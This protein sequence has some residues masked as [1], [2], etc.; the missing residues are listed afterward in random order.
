MCLPS[1]FIPTTNRDRTKM[2]QQGTK[3][4]NLAFCLSL[5]LIVSISLIPNILSA[6][7]EKVFGLND[8]SVLLPLEDIRVNSNLLKPQDL[9][10]GGS[11]LPVD[12]FERLP[13][14]RMNMTAQDRILMYESLRVLA[15]RIDPCFPATA[16]PMAKCLRQIRLVWQPVM[17]QQGKVTTVDAAVHTFHNLQDHEFL[18]LLKDWP[19]SSNPS[20]N[21]QVH[22]QFSLGLD[23][24]KW[25]MTKQILLNNIGRQNLWKV[26][27]M[28]LRGQD[29]IWLFGGFDVG[30]QGLVA[31]SIPRLKGQK[32]QFFVN[33]PK[34]KEDF[35][36]GMISPLP[37]VNEDTLNLLTSDSK[38]IDLTKDE[39]QIIQEIWASQR[40]DNPNFHSPQT[41]DCV[42]CHVSQAARSFAEVKFEGL[43]QKWQEQDFNYINSDFRL[44]NTS[45]LKSHTMNIRAF[46]YFE[47]QPAISQR[48]INETAQVASAISVWLN[49]NT[50]NS[51][52]TKLSP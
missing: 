15:I 13:A 52:R 6:S 27:F 7:A 9:G 17:I 12:F 29:H 30:N 5:G 8:V 36:N 20:V 50:A 38:K 28:A 33:G 10:V 49:Q 11:L 26:T 44:E 39:D 18:K 43:K 1:R 32:S 4:M 21:L 24:S 37:E 45:P 35:V 16:D 42:S 3:A 2:N 51:G 22:P 19:L 40:I 23:D 31:A 34:A 48:T 14:L 47:D 25:Q 41:L 46:G